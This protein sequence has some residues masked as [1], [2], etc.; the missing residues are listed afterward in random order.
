MSVVNY[1]LKQESFLYF[2]AMLLNNVFFIALDIVK[3]DP[4]VFAPSFK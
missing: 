1:D 3:L 2:D 4:P